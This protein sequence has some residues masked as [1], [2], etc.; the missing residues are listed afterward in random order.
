MMHSS[1]VFLRAF[2]FLKL[3]IIM[4]IVYKLRPTCVEFNAIRSQENV[5]T[6]R[7]I[8]YQGVTN[9]LRREVLFYLPALFC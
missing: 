8:T 3:F 6:I 5:N 7:K 4:F 2:T 9:L 1:R